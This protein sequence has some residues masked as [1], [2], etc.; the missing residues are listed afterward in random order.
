MKRRDFMKMTVG[1]LTALLI[2]PVVGEVVPETVSSGCPSRTASTSSRSVSSKCCCSLRRGGDGAFEKVGCKDHANFKDEKERW[3]Y[4]GWELGDDDCG[5]IYQLHHC[6]PFHL[7]TAKTYVVTEFVGQIVPLN[8]EEFQ[9]W[10]EDMAERF[11][12]P[13]QHS[14]LLVNSKSRRFLWAS[15][16]GGI[17]KEPLL[18]VKHADMNGWVYDSEEGMMYG[19]P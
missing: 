16:A 4:E 19:N 7:S 12:L 2:K 14:W 9:V 17:V 1:S 6:L 8:S 11:P 10:F 5:Q 18:G 13:Y 3:M 15:P